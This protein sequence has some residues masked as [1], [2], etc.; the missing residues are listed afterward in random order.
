MV[1]FKP[2]SSGV[3]RFELS[4]LDKNAAAE[5]RKVCR[6]K[7]PGRKVVRLQDCL[8]FIPAPKVSCPSGCTAFYLHTA[9]CSFTLASTTSQDWLSALSLLAFQVQISIKSWRLS[10]LLS[11]SEAIVSLFGQGENKLYS[12][13]ELDSTMRKLLKYLLHLS[14]HFSNSCAYTSYVL[15]CI[16]H[17]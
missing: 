2:S 9:Q 8:S 15:S 11:N 13:L 16:L 7:T 10:P 17:L 1:L 12:H 14:L 5:Q 3:G 6:Q 4:V